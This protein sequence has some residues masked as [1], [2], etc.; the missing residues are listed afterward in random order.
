MSNLIGQIKRMRPLRRIVRTALYKEIVHSNDWR[1]HLA[2]FPERVVLR[3]EGEITELEKMVG[4][5]LGN[6]H[7]DPQALAAQRALKPAGPETAPHQVAE[8]SPSRA[9]FEG[10]DRLAQQRSDQ[11]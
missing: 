2:E 1:D 8:L 6:W 9:A 3:Y 7:A 11:I 4:K 10:F 5:D